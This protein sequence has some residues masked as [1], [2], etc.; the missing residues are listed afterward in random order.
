MSEV[1]S[2]KAIRACELAIANA[3]DECSDVQVQQHAWRCQACNAFSVVQFD[4]SQYDT[5]ATAAEGLA[6]ACSNDHAEQSPICF[7]MRWGSQVVPM[8]PARVFDADGDPL[9]LSEL[10]RPHLAARDE[11]SRASL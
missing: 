4:A 7:G 3:Q 5:T 2:A 8:V 10:A 11:V 1:F 9:W 6:V